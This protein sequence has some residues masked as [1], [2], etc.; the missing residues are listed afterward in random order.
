MSAQLLQST[1]QKPWRPKLKNLIPEIFGA[2]FTAL[3]TLL[4]VA[5]TPLK[6][7]LGF[8]IVLII[9]AIDGLIIS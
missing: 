3:S 1:P 6:G 4:I 9:M 2:L 7:K 8:S 5:V